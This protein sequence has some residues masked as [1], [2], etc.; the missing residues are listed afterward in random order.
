MASATDRT[1]YSCS[2][3][4][5]EDRASEPAKARSLASSPVLLIV[6]ARTREVTI[7]RERRSN[8][9]GVA[10]TSPEIENFHVVGYS[11]ASLLKIERESIALLDVA[12]ISRA[13]TTLSKSP[14]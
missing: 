4:S 10:P 6:P 9:S 7:P 14:R 13:S 1:A 12:V 8:S 2:A 11:S 5:F 3:R